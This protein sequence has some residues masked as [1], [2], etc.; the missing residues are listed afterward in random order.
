M[1]RQDWI[2]GSLGCIVRPC[3]KPTCLSPCPPKKGR[4]RNSQLLLLY[5]T[6]SFLWNCNPQPTRS[7][8]DLSQDYQIFLSKSLAL[9]IKR[10]P[11]SS[12]GPESVVLS[13]SQVHFY[14]G[15]LR[16]KEETKQPKK[17]SSGLTKGHRTLKATQKKSKRE[18]TATAFTQTW[19]LG[20]P[21]GLKTNQRQETITLWRILGK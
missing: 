6:S 15:A 21:T 20:W 4:T 12:L 7:A 10:Q 8:V 3:L 17:R 19:W 18:R 16:D 2:P 5:W 1:L 14:V 13:K 11:N 9:D